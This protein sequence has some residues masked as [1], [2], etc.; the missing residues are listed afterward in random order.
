[1]LSSRDHIWQRSRFLK[2]MS[3][4]HYCFFIRC[5]CNIDRWLFFSLPSLRFCI[6]MFPVS[7]SLVCS[8]IFFYIMVQFN[9][10]CRMQASHM[11]AKSLTFLPESSCSNRRSNSSGSESI[12]NGV[13]CF[14]DS[15]WTSSIPSGKLYESL[16]Q[17]PTLVP[18]VKEG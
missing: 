1:M 11:V 8:N 7:H 15:C 6:S 2:W 10:A 16:L 14:C 3:H 17:S 4:D 18:A 9:N 13:H 12:S 5:I